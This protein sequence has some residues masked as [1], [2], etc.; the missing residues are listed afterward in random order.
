MH[1]FNQVRLPADRGFVFLGLQNWLVMVTDIEDS[2]MTI[3]PFSLSNKLVVRCVLAS[4]YRRLC[5]SV[6]PLGSPLVGPSISN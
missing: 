5:L 2:L 1:A 3:V 6:G 4:L